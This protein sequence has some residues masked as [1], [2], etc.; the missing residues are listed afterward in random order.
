MLLLFRLSTGENWHEVMGDCQATPR[1]RVRVEVGV[2]VRVRVD[3]RLPGYPY[4]VTSNL[5]LASPE[6]RPNG[7]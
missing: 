1:V 6:L 3:G 7:V 5:T 2:E 4:S